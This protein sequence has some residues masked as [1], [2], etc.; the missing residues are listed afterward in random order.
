MCRGPGPGERREQSGITSRRIET[1]ALPQ[2]EYRGHVIHKPGLQAEAR[3]GRSVP[4]DRPE[5]AVG[6]LRRVGV[7]IPG[8]THSDHAASLTLGTVHGRNARALARE[9]TRQARWATEWGHAAGAAPGRVMG[10]LRLW[11]PAAVPS[12]TLPPALAVW[13]S[14]S[15]AWP[16]CRGLWPWRGWQAASCTSA[17]RCTV[18]RRRSGRRRLERHAAGQPAGR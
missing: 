7:R 12:L 15:H 2:L 4:L 3:T 18:A 11:V 16:G 14:E 10:G 6:S 13:R 5:L 8:L 17:V 1:L 9:R